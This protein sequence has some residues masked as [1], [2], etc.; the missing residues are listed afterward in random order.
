MSVFFVAHSGWGREA[1]KRVGHDAIN[2]LTAKISEAVAINKEAVRY[3]YVFKRIIAISITL[4]SVLCA[5]AQ[6]DVVFSHYWLMETSFNPAAAG[7]G[8]KLNAVGAYQMS[9]TGYEGNPNT[10]YVG[11]DL[12]L[13]FMRQYHGVGASLLNDKI[14]AFTHQRIAGQYAFRKNLFGGMISAGVQLGLVMEKFDGTKIDLDDTSDP[15]FNKSQISGN[16]LDVGF[17]LYYVHKQW[18]VGVSGQHLTGPTVALGETNEMKVDPTF[19]LTGGYNIK[20]RNP[21]ITVPTSVLARYDGTAYRADITAR[22][23][24]QNEKKR[25]YAGVGY[26]PTNSVTGYI[27]GSFQGINVG[28]SYEM[29]TGG[30]GLG[31]GTHELM[32]SYQLD[33]NLQKKGRNLHKSARIL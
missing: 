2:H 29:F 6:Y 1:G 27:G 14:G 15:A 21:Y 22:V 28:Y 10:F 32:V 33:I 7:K 18:Y 17:G 8:N 13:Y 30:A 3:L 20:L 4:F 24:Y 26:S 19:Y 12:P 5:R 31:N 9:F 11:A 16:A 25:M 23:V